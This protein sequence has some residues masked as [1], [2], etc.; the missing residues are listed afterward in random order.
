MI[1]NIEKESKNLRN[2]EIIAEIN[3]DL[4]FERRTFIKRSQDS[5]L[6]VYE[7][8][9][10]IE[11]ETVGKRRISEDIGGL[12]NTLINQT[13]ISKRKQTR[14]CELINRTGSIA[15]PDDDSYQSRL[16]KIQSKIE[17]QQRKEEC[18]EGYDSVDLLLTGL[19]I[20]LTNEKETT[21]YPIIN[22]SISE[23]H[24]EKYTT[25]KASKGQTCTSVS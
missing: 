9:K 16:I 14:D 22:L 10:Q 3:K 12:D 18:K 24:F 8:K 11:R 7:E 1:I 19:S 6:E 4:E 15:N 2:S 20:I 5:K 13:I 23:V 21:F 17:T 25:L